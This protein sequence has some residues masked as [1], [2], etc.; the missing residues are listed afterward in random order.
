MSLLV[1][2]LCVTIDGHR[3]L[4][5]VTMT[6]G[7]GTVRAFVGPS[8]VGKSTLL[9]AIAGIVHSASGRIVIDDRDVTD[10]PP[11]QRS[12]GMVFQ[13]DHLFPHMNVAANIG[14]GL[15][16]AKVPAPAIAQRVDELLLLV[17]LPGFARRRPD[18]LSGGESKRVALARALAA[19]PRVLLLDEPLTG[20][21]RTL[22]DRLALD[23]RRILIAA[24]TT[25]LL[26]THDLDEAGQLADAITRLVPTATGSRVSAT[27]S[28]TQDMT[29]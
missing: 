3:I 15:R 18:S 14:F 2:D 7:S 11:H 23:L 29:S 21:D 4:D 25:S 5:E 6:V 19:R 9:R 20:L 26:V 1:Q 10:L 24:G 27:S 28:P 13:A 22:H 8:G 16:M 17:D 12:V